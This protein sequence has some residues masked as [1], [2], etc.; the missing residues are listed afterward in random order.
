ML[1]KAGLVF[2]LFGVL[3]CS[4]SSPKLEYKVFGDQVSKGVSL[5]FNP[6]VDILFVVDDSGSMDSHQARLAKNV[7]VLTQG[8]Q[9][10]KVIDYHIGVIT[11]S[12]DSYYNSGFA[13]GRLVSMVG[14]PK[15]ID[16]STPGGLQLLKNY[17][18]VGTNGSA[19]EKFFQ[20]IQAALTPPLSTGENSGFLRQDAAL[21]MIFITDTDDQSDNPMTGGS[22]MPSD[23]YNFIVNLKGG[24][25]K[26][27]IP[28]GIFI[29]SNVAET[30]DCP[31]D[32]YSPNKLEA[33]INQL[34]GYEYNLC[35]P[36]YNSN[37]DVL[38]K[39]IVNRVSRVLYLNRRPV[40]DTIVV[41]YGNDLIPNDV[42]N[43]WTYDPERNAIV[44][45]EALMQSLTGTSSKM[46]ISY[47]AVPDYL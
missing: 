17:L 19:T 36:N 16:R 34:N 15:Y 8:I 3:S 42:N 47:T 40:P 14:G 25:S 24:D 4:P 7:D 41:K 9:N 39:D 28:Y 27:V 1:K 37:L 6:K 30:S 2:T 46:D 13:G 10:N 22:Y 11:T 18:H 44:F 43:G 45:G 20:P 38:G 33:V 32:E 12:M 5:D 31:R 21:V 35:D 23:F 29:P 26:K